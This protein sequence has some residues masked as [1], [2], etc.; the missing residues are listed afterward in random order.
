MTSDTTGARLESMQ[1][2]YN[3]VDRIRRIAGWTCFCL[4]ILACY[5]GQFTEPVSRGEIVQYRTGFI[6]S[7]CVWIASY[8]FL[9]LFM[10]LGKRFVFWPFFSFASFTLVWVLASY[11]VNHGFVSSPI[12][13]ILGT[14]WIYVAM[15]IC[16]VDMFLIEALNDKHKEMAKISR[17]CT[18]TV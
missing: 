15:F 6:V 2:A 3:I 8:F 7:V 11:H 4:G 17:A 14:I 9:T 5:V 16:P 13:S 12:Q 18:V 10:G 1:R